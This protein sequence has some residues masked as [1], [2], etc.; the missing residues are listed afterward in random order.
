[1]EWL[2]IPAL[3]FAAWLQPTNKGR[4]YIGNPPQSPWV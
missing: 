2:I 1:M 3:L 4:T